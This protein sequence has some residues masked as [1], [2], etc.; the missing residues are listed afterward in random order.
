MV[1]QMQHFSEIQRYPMLIL[2]L[3]ILPLD[4]VDN[5]NSFFQSFKS[6]VTLRVR[7]G[8]ARR[9]KYTLKC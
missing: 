8:L 4:S 3:T 7:A 6:E 5:L 1:W 9:V 2:T